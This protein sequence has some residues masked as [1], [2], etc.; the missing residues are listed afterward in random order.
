MAEERYRAAEQR[1]LLEID[2]ER[3]QATKL[4]KELN[5]TR[6][7][8]SDASERQRAEVS[9]LQTEIGQLRQQTGMLEGN[10][11]AVTASKQQIVAELDIVRDQLNERIS[12]SSAARVEAEAEEYGMRSTALIINCNTFQ[13]R[14]ARTATG[15]E[16]DAWRLAAEQAT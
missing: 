1:A 15:I 16:A 4:Q 7:A 3:M 11:Q 6:G 2:R 10:L 5:S 13:T 14:A 8:A 9:S 12:Q